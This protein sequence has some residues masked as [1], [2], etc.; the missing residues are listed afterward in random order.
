MTTFFPPPPIL[1]F[2][3]FRPSDGLL[4][5]AERWRKAHD[6]H[7]QRQNFHYQALHQPGIVCGLGVTLISSDANEPEQYKDGRGVKL[8]P[9]IAI[10]LKG[11][12]IIVPQAENVQ[13]AVEPPTEDP[14]MVYLVVS[15]RDPD[16]LRIREGSEIVREQFRI[17]VK[18][19]PPS[20][21]E[22][23]VCRIW[24]P[25]NQPIQLKFTDDVFFPGYFNPDFRFRQ[26]ATLRPLGIVKIAQIEHDD[27]QHNINFPNL[28]YLIGST[29]ILYPKLQ[30]VEP[31]GLINWKGEEQQSEESGGKI[32][33]RVSDLEQYDLLYV[34]GSQL[35]L[36]PQQI[37]ALKS[38][39]DRGGVLFVDS[40]GENSPI[41]N[42]VKELFQNELSKKESEQKESEQLKSIG[43][44]HPLRRM[45]FL[46]GAFPSGGFGQPVNLFCGGGVIL[47]TGNLASVW[48]LD[49]QMS[50]SREVL[51]S[52]QELGVNILHYAWQRRIMTKLQQTL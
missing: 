25:P 34:T 42:Y 18:T 24:L 11:N 33:W 51:R 52:A 23:E 43:K 26:W 2:D 48:G 45:P 8:Q 22:V 20:E 38:Y 17:D 32:R 14:L 47:A 13:I 21:L 50:I 35:N 36:S 1:P 3:R 40:L 41:T 12:P 15:Y 30:G 27:P 28:D 49:Q 29:E 39:I 44:R 6:Y 7:R 19:S 46:F 4:I 9:G 5:N 37:K 16:E 10:D 31:V